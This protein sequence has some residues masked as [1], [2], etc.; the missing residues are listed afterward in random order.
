MRNVRL[1]AAAAALTASGPATAAERPSPPEAGSVS[2]G[3]VA[4]DPTGGS[5]KLF[6]H[7]RHALA[8]HVGFG[9]FHFGAG[10][11]DLSYLFHSKP[12]G[13]KDGFFALGYVGVGVGVAFWSSKFGHLGPLAPEPGDFRKAA[14]FFRAPV[15]GIDFF[16]ASVPIDI[17]LETAYSPLVGPYLSAWNIDFGLGARYWF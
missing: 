1:L 6:L 13:G 10:R 11:V 12:W 3:I 9:F 15:L 8:S 7:P 2:L 17:F 4:G 5:A 16:L 14:F